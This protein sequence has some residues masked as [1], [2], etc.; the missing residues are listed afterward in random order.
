MLHATLVL[1]QETFLRGNR[2]KDKRSGA[3]R[4]RITIFD[5]VAAKDW[6][7]QALA[8]ETR[9]NA[10]FGATLTAQRKLINDATRVEAEIEV[11]CPATPPT[12]LPAATQTLL[13]AMI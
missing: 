13:V 3:D 1:L 12:V 8:F 10:F 11:H 6:H 4:A 7:E 9:I 5:D 2:N